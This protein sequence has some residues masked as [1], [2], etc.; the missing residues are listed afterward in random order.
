[1]KVLITGGCGFVGVNLLHYLYE[2]HCTIR[3][4]D[5]LSTG[6]K[7]YIDRL[8]LAES[9][10]LIMGDIRNKENVGEAVEGMDAIVHLAAHTNVIESLENPEDSWDINVTGTF[11]LLEACRKNGVEE[12]VLASS[13]AV[14][15][16]QTPPINESKIP[17]PL[18]PY[19]ASKLAGEALCSAYY[20]SYGLKTTIL[21]FSN[22]Y[23][24][25]ADHKTSV[26]AKFIELAR[27]EI[28]FTIYGDGNQTRDFIHVDDIC[29][30][31]YL[32]LTNQTSHGEVFQIARGKETTIN[33]LVEI[34]N[35][36]AGKNIRT[37]H[38]PERKGEIRRNYSDIGKAREVL[39]FEP[40]VEL[41]EGLMQ[42][43]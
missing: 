15:G 23:G 41:K 13:N 33:E 21:R 42:L 16:E 24:P 6:K 38:E 9:P 35:K 40:Q 29:H 19:G 32:S 12:F 1:M 20:H 39:G 43:W 8:P 27:K 30:A 22:L 37:I 25:F 3:I 18:S 14:A 10:E 7:E 31:I 11:N 26:I 2:K 5:N 17:Q 36:I 34:L 4:L 28:P